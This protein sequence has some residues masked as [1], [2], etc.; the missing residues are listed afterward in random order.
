MGLTVN[1]RQVMQELG[2]LLERMLYPEALLAE[3]GEKE[4]GR[5][6]ER[7]MESKIDPLG[8]AWE[9]WATSTREARERKGN[10]GQGLLFDT[11]QLLDSIH[12][13]LSERE[14]AIGTSVD[15]ATYLQ[16]GT[17]RMPER[18]FLGWTPESV[19]QYE[20]YILNYLQTGST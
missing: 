6:R 2:R 16:Q 15:Y 9:P 19:D 3:I 17:F 12:F 14:V 7:I 5:V 18:E 1:D 20:L 4:V 11:G 8:A 13:S 10:E